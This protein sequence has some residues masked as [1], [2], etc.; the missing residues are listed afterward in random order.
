MKGISRLFSNFA[1]HV[2]RSVGNVKRVFQVWRT[3]LPCSI[4]GLSLPHWTGSARWW[5][6]LFSAVSPTAGSASNCGAFSGNAPLTT[7]FLLKRWRARRTPAMFIWKLRVWRRTRR[8]ES[9]SRR[10]IAPM[11]TKKNRFV[12]EFKLLS[13]T[14]QSARVFFSV[15]EDNE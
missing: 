8:S 11:L 3:F 10:R 14:F 15:D 4:C 2:R 7:S 1:Y 5:S 13:F 12:Q 9:S 6:G